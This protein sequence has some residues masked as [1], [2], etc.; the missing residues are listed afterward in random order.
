MRRKTVNGYE[1]ID[2]YRTGRRYARRATSFIVMRLL[3]LRFLVEP[4]PWF[5]ASNYDK[6]PEHVALQ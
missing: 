5:V 2:T 3:G 6:T 1:N 4:T